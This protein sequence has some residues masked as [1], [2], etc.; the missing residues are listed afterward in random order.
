MLAEEVYKFGLRPMNKIARWFGNLVVRFEKTFWRVQIKSVLGK[1][2]SRGYFR[3]AVSNTAG[4][5]YSR[6]DIDFLVAYIFAEDLCY[7]FPVHVVEQK[8]S[9]CVSPGSKI[10]RYEQYRENWDLM[11]LAAAAEP[12]PL[13][14]P[15]EP[16]AGAAMG[17]VST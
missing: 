1:S 14:S 4:R 10:S 7:V 6:G 13:T 11:R 16:P 8:K 2:P 3:V 5:T 17:T 12:A 15:A 9:I